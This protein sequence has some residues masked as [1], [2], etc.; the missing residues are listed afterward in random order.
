VTLMLEISTLSS[1]ASVEPSPGSNPGV[2]LGGDLIPLRAVFSQD[3]AN[4]GA[5][6][7]LVDNDG[8]IQVP[9]EAVGPLTTVGGFVLAKNS[10][11]A[12]SAGVLTLHHDDA[13]G[14]SYA[15][16]QFLSDAKGD[17]R[18]PAAAGSELSAHG[19]V[20]ILEET[21]LAL[22]RTKPSQNNLSIK[23]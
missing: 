7:Y 11:N 20:P 4:H 3:E 2:T 5:S 21:V 6:R 10:D 13:A 15:G 9:L 17:V 18:V 12:I 14:C 22:G 1:K 8:L 16:R 23:G 19:F